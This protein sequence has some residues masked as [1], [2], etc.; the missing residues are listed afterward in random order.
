MPFHTPL[1]AFT[2]WMKDNHATA[3]RSSFAFKVGC[4][5]SD[6]TIHMRFRPSGLHLKFSEDDALEFAE[7]LGEHAKTIPKDDTGEHRCPVE[8]YR[9]DPDLEPSYW[10]RWHYWVVSDAQSMRV[11]I[12][13]NP[14]GLTVSLK[15]GD[16][17]SMLCQVQIAVNR[18]DGKL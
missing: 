15:R 8:T 11:H 13:F 2:Q 10:P 3:G 4:R 18:L 7:V 12:T 1:E 16:V 17:F 14:P 6:R 9:Y 5:R